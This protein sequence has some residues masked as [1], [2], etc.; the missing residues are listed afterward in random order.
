MAQQALVERSDGATKIDV[1]VTITISILG[2]Y[3]YDP[4]VHLRSV[5]AEKHI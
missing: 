1:H 5:G 4:T 2:A 3:K